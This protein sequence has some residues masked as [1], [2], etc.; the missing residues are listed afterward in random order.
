MLSMG[1]GGALARLIFRFISLPMLDARDTLSAGFC[2]FVPLT[3][4]P[5]ETP[6]ATYNVR[7]G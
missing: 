1:G 6:E 4:L 2:H 7:G 5:P 3:A